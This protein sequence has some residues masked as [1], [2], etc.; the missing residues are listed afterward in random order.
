M[1][2]QDMEKT[3]I[4]NFQKEIKAE[5]YQLISEE[6]LAFIV[7]SSQLLASSKVI[8]SSYKQVV[9]SE[10]TFH[11]CEF[12]GVTFENCVFENCNFE[13]SHLRGCNFK[14]CSFTD[15]KW[16][17]SSSNKSIYVACTLPASMEE[18]CEGQVREFI[19]QKQDYSTDIYIE[20]ALVA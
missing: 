3:V 4:T 9:F 6:N 15:C 20:L 12:Q 18:A 19:I 2:S 7:I 11:S 1:F 13:F 14:N 17:H 5:A 8:D 16:V 10:C